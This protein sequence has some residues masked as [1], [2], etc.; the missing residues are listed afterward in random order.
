MADGTT[1]RTVHMIFSGDEVRDI[2]SGEMSMVWRGRHATKPRCRKGDTIVVLEEWTLSFVADRSQPHVMANGRS[3]SRFPLYWRATYCG[4][5]QGVTWKRAS[6]MPVC[7]CRIR[8][9]V[10]AVGGGRYEDKWAWS[11]RWNQVDLTEGEIDG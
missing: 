3:G 4:S 2:L 10:S 5:E 1:G 7:A 11:Y 8:L 6:Y 9:R